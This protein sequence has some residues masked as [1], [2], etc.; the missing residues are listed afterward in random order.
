MK[1]IF[2]ATAFFAAATCSAAPAAPEEAD[3]A[4]LLGDAL[5]RSPVLRAAEARLESARRLPG[6]A[7]APPDP[8]VS[9]SYVNDGLSSLTLGDT[10]FSGL[11]LTWTQEVPYPGKLRRS[12][13]VAETEIE[14]ADRD[15]ERLKL[16]VAA[17]VKTGHA[18]LYRLDRT[19]AL[20][21]ET[22]SLLDSL[23][24]AARSRYE[25]GQG[26]QESIF[27]AQI[28]IVRLQAEQ[29]RVAQDRKVAEA[30]LNAAIGRSPQMPIGRVPRLPEAAL[31]DSV[32]NLAEAA[33]GASPGIRRLEAAVRR[34][35]AGEARAR[36]DLKP[37][38][39]WSAGYQYRGSLD[40]MVMGM[41]GVR[42]PLYRERKQA[43][44]LLQAGSDLLAS[45]HEL[46]DLQVRTRALVRELVAQAERAARLIVLYEQGVIPQARGALESAQ[47]S[48]GVGRIAFFDLLNDLMILLN[49]RVELTEQESDRLKALAAL[50]P[51]VARELVVV[52]GPDTGQGGSR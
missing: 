40:P 52:P 20:L 50:E 21:E 3:L 1:K 5:A 26:I 8:E 44:A 32:D 43:Q 35:E 38:F 11:S 47:T 15:L 27:K 33:V 24:Q 29:D 48:Y 39:V 7:Q 4:L 45:R 17:A 18:D 49:S 34:A 12:G 31:P 19:A 13:V 37:D 23:A 2:L 25:V 10:E 41:V 14:M 16:E 22:R 46:T 30:R 36:I 6:Q 51:L 9:L 28:E 42:L